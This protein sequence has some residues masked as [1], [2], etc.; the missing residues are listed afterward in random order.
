MRLALGEREVGSGRF[1]KLD[2]EDRERHVH[3]VMKL[4][5]GQLRGR[6]ETGF[7]LN[8]DECLVL[9]EAQSFRDNLAHEFWAANFSSLH[10]DEGIALLE[11]E[12][13]IL[14]IQF[15]KLGDLLISATGL[16]ARSYVEWVRMSASDR[17][18]LDQ[19]RRLIDEAWQAHRDA[20]HI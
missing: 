4:N 2:A 1:G 7:D 11:E 17:A 13:A 18:W 8:A 6:I 20:G 10:S 19:K 15:Q 9:K 14:E 3:K 5:F 16:D 12:C